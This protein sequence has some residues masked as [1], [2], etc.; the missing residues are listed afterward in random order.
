MKM[1]KNWLMIVMLMTISAVTG[2]AGMM[3]ETGVRK[4]SP[5]LNPVIGDSKIIH[6]KSVLYKAGLTRYTF[7]SKEPEPDPSRALIKFKNAF[8]ANTALIFKKEKGYEFVE[9]QN[10]LDFPEN[11][12]IYIE[13]RLAFMRGIPPIMAS[14]GSTRWF[15]YF[16]GQYAFEIY[17]WQF[18]NLIGIGGEESVGQELSRKS[19]EDFLKKIEKISKKRQARSP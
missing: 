19:V 12:T 4:E 16:K 17:E 5:A 8:L 15:V 7:V 9:I 13:I 3:M 2:C 11:P 6:C 14:V 18:A 10:N 1:I